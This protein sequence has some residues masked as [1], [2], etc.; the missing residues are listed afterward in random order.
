MASCALLSRILAIKPRHWSEWNYTSIVTDVWGSQLAK[1]VPDSAAHNGGHI[2]VD[3]R[4]GKITHSELNASTA[5][6]VYYRVRVVINEKVTH[7][8]VILIDRYAKTGEL[9]EP[10]GEAKWSG[11]VAAALK[12]AI[13][14]LAAPEYRYWM[15]LDYCP[16]TGPQVTS[17]DANCASWTLLYLAL[18][19]SCPR[20]SREEV[21]K[22]MGLKSAE[23]LAKWNTYMMDYTQSV[24]YLADS[25]NDGTRQI[26]T[27]SYAYRLAREEP[28]IEAEAF[29]TRINKVDADFRVFKAQLDGAICSLSQLP[30][31]P[32]LGDESKDAYLGY[33]QVKLADLRL[34]DYY[35]AESEPH[36]PIDKMGILTKALTIP[37]SRDPVNPAVPMVLAVGSLIFRS[38][39]LSAVWL[40]SGQWQRV[41]DYVDPQKPYSY[42]F[43]RLKEPVVGLSSAAHPAHR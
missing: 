33:D 34:G 9:F 42:T 40:P 14:E 30:P 15:P 5:A 3:P 17:G 23:L 37:H 19:L 1:V 36:E 27:G 16:R 28:T 2:V 39:D 11:M 26:E 6:L 20:W 7:A 4:S 22:A 12:T 10:H 43:F 41:D 8:N 31:V 21:V 35:A 32:N 24:D 38:D 25:V 18:R 29:W 13:P